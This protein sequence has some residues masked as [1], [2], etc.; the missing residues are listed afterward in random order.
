M[1]RLVLALA[2]GCVSVLP[3]AAP[4]NAQF[5]SGAYGGYTGYDGY[6]PYYGYDG[7]RGYDGYSGYLDRDD[8]RWRLFHDLHGRRCNFEAHICLQ[9]SGGCDV[10]AGS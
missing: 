1:K 9:W 2:V 4:A 3:L 8:W 10:V 6:G 5:G 7:Y